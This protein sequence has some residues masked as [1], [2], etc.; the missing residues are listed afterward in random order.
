VDKSLHLR[1]QKAKARMQLR[2]RLAKGEV[3]L[4][5]VSIATSALSC[6]RDSPLILTKVRL[7]ESEP[8]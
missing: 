6:R 1:K 2:Q 3:R 5:Q 4:M 8:V 7:P